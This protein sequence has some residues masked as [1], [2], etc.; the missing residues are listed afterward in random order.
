MNKI[1]RTGE[2]GISLHIKNAANSNF[3]MRNNRF[4]QNITH[5]IKC[6][7]GP[8]S[9]TVDAT[10]CWWGTTN[11]MAITELVYDNTAFKRI[12]QIY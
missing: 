7:S 9:V 4:E 11:V 5:A 1:E 12:Q 6:E 3:D 2:A 10:H 8:S